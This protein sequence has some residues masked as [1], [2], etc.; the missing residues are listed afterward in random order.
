MTDTNLHLFK[1]I[2]EQ[3]PISTQILSIN[4]ET[5]M[6]NKAWEK[7]WNVK[8]KYLKGYNML[9]DKQLVETGIMPFIKRGFKGEVV[10]IPPIKYIPAKSVKVKGAV[11]YRWLGAIMYP[12]KDERGK[13]LFIVLQHN[14]ITD[15]KESEEKRSVNEERLRMALDAGSIGVW[16]WNIE[17]NNLTWTENVYKIH[18]VNKAKFQ[19]NLNNFFKLIH[20]DDF[21]TIKSKINNSIKNHIPFEAEFRIVT[22]KGDVKWVYTKA[23]TKYDDLGNAVRMLG[24]TSDTTER[25]ENEKR[26]DEFVS[27]ASHELK[28]PI[29][30]QMIFGELLEREIN[31]RG[32]SDL[33]H[34]IK[35]INLQTNKMVK[36]I[37]DLLELSRINTTNLRLQTKSVKFD[38]LVKDIVNEIQLSTKHKLILKGKT[39]KIVKCDRERIGQVIT[40]LLTN[41]VKYSPHAKRV[42]ISSKVDN[43]EILLSIQDF[44]IGIGKH[45]HDKIFERFFRVADQD[46]KT[47]PGM[48]IGLYISREIISRHDGKIWVESKKGKGSKF[49]LSL[50][51][52]K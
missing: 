40:N 43:D 18:E 37:E 48:G 26:R 51:Y 11:P 31:K 14:D 28:T 32:Y 41:A 10:V 24:A 35:R 36:L 16:D 29:T 8:S 38:D 30:S 1:T 7:L 17:N 44:G 25:T 50:P 27:T 52:A 47:F 39:R 49:H 46:Q 20:K 2:F 21:Q 3:T 33:T 23:V 15:L 13:L 4:G 22:P 6:V 42:I 5:A 34:Y 12:I 19:L 9:K 45:Y